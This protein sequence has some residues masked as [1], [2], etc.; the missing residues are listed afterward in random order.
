MASPSTIGFV[1][2]LEPAD[3]AYYRA[4]LIDVD[5]KEYCVK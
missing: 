1:E 3:R 4:Q 2:V 5:G